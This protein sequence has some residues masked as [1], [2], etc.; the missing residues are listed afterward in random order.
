MPKKFDR[1]PVTW[2]T[3]GGKHIP[4]F[5]KDSKDDKTKELEYN[6]DADT[7]NIERFGFFEAE[8][9]KWLRSS[10]YDAKQNAYDYVTRDFPEVGEAMRLE[11]FGENY[12][13][14]VKV[15]RVGGM[16]NGIISFF[17]RRGTAESYAKRFGD[18]GDIEWIKIRTE[19]L[20]PTFSG[21]GELW[22]TKDDIV[23]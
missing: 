9:G 22:A 21:S 19:N 4:I 16:G 5:D 15:Y 8:S 12:P 7:E 14:I 2:I 10:D 17:P 3:R 18:I 20:I 23:K 11:A 6:E 1:E 13:E